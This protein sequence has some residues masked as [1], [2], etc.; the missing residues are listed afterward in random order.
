MPPIFTISR[1]AKKNYWEIIGNHLPLLL[2]SGFILMAAY[3]LPAVQC[4]LN[5]CV[6]LHLT[7]HPCP[8]CGF[9][10]GFCACAH[11]NW[12]NAMLDCPLAC[13]LFI[14]T[15]LIFFYNFI[16]VLLGVCGWR[17]QRGSWLQLTTNKMIFIC[18]LFIFLLAANWLYRVIS[19]IR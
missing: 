19:G 13:L 6:F 17:I 9:T 1:P 4:P 14:L 2:I 11:G 15:V 18:I 5:F 10:R 12:M 16:A 7:G 3:F 8:T